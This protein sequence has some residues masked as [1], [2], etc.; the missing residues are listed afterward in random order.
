MM[1]VREPTPMASICAMV[2]GM[3]LGRFKR[4]RAARA[5]SNVVSCNS[6][7]ARV[8]KFMRGFIG[9][10]AKPLQRGQHDFKMALASSGKKGN[11]CR[12]VLRDVIASAPCYRNG[13]RCHTSF[14][15]AAYDA[16]NIAYA[17]SANY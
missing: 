4:P 15:R 3:Y 14:E 13:R 2:S 10:R 17:S 1:I 8:T 12:E 6:S 11:S 5:A 7:T 16:Q 9:K